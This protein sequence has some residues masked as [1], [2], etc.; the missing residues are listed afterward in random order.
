MPALEDLTGKRFGRLVVQI[1]TASSGRRVVWTCLCDCG[2]ACDVK[3]MLL[4]SGKT[5]SCGCVRTENSASL[6]KGKNHSKDEIGKSYG[7]LTV[8]KRI[9][10]GYW[11]C[12]CTCGNHI[13]A[14]GRRLRKGLTTSCGCQKRHKTRNHPILSALRQKYRVYRSSAAAR[15]LEFNLPFLY[16]A[17]LVVRPCF[18]CGGP[19]RQEIRFR[20]KKPTESADVR[21]NGLDRLE[22]S[23]G[24]LMHNVV[25]SCWRCN[26]SKGVM[27]FRDFMQFVASVYE[28]HLDC[29]SRLI[30]ENPLTKAFCFQ[31]ELGKLGFES[32][33]SLAP[34]SISQ[35]TSC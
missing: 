31:A 14:F 7:A 34:Y 1:Q 20:S 4:K 22:N 25:P 23:R 3:A 17:S 18:Y 32:V 11:D 21:T 13:R 10:Y 33:V 27:S 6:F 30:P 24:Y 19:P 12:R 2:N 29:P 9:R 5:R 15:N 26:S 16:F 35:E 28:K 8:V